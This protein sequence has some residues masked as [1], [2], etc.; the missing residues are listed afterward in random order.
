M[1]KKN[2]TLVLFLITVSAVSLLITTPVPAITQ[3]T[4]CQVISAGRYHSL[5]VK[6]DGT[7]WAWGYNNFGQ[8]GDGT[9]DDSHSPVRIISGTE[10][11]PNPSGVSV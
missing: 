1:F 3:T 10:T 5:S 2:L 8:L 11:I 4:N 9:T 7:L 6:S